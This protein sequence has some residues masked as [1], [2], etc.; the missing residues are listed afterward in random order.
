LP[1]EVVIPAMEAGQESARVLRWLKEVGASVHKGEPLIE[2]ETDKVT[3]ELEAPASGTLANVTA[4]AG[5]DVPVGTTIGVIV[6]AGDAPSE[7][8]VLASPKARRLAAEAGVDLA[9]LAGGGPIRARDVAAAAPARTGYRS[10]PLEGMRRRAAE[11]L[12]ASYREAPHVAFRRAVKATA[13]VERVA[14]RRDAGEPASLLAA[15]AEAAAGALTAHPR[16]NAHFVDETIRIFDEVALGIAVALEDGLIVPVVHDAAGKDLGALASEIDAL[17]DR[18][19]AG[20]LTPSD[21][22][23]STFTLTNLGMF[24][25]DDFTPILNPPEVAILGIGAVRPLPADIGG[26]V[27]L[28]PVLS[29]TLVVDHRAVDGAVAA[30]FLTDLVGRL[31]SGRA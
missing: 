11:R 30:A 29:L 19:R 21:V 2:I 13:L 9:E 31:E 6:A 14:A 15:I 28:C 20:T 26:E 10:V 17:A 16:L 8:R 12:S 18:A 25:V 3:V 4:S 5:D 7:A 1:A 23:D 22:R 27:A 24:A